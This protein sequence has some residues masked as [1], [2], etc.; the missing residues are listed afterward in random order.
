MIET[1]QL[2]RWQLYIESISNNPPVY[3]TRDASCLTEGT[4]SLIGGALYTIEGRASLI[5]GPDYMIEG[6]AYMTQ[7]EACLVKEGPAYS[8]V[9]LWGNYGTHCFTASRKS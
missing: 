7:A 5:Q 8:L 2:V 9:A 6:A 3:I 4:A 1:P